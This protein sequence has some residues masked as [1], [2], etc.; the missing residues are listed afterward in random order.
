MPL[1]AEQYH[2]GRS[3]SPRGTTLLSSRFRT[4]VPRRMDDALVLVLCAMGPSHREACMAC[5]VPGA[6]DETQHRG[7][8]A[9]DD[10]REPA[11]CHARLGHVRRMMISSHGICSGRLNTAISSYGGNGGHD[12]DRRSLSSMKCA[13]YDSRNLDS[14]VRC[15]FFPELLTLRLTTDSAGTYMT[16]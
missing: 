10:R 7:R 6:C 8:E 16:T 14:Y 1:D 5:S 11:F 15:F 12:D 9:L 13:P 3:P 2:R 4:T